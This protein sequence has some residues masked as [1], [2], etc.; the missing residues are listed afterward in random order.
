[1]GARNA[2][3]ATF[4]IPVIVKRLGQVDLPEDRNIAV[5]LMSQIDS[6]LL[7]PKTLDIYAKQLKNSNGIQTL[8]KITRAMIEDLDAVST[9][10]QI[11]ESIKLNVAL[12]MDL[13]QFGGLDVLEKIIRTHEKDDYLQVM[14]PKLMKVVLGK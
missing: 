1:M 3:V 12:M 2:K 14:I 10:A 13:I 7:N 9:F 6:Q 8:I 11:M 5:D 4:S